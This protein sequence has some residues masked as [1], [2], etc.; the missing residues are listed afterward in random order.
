MREL[1]ASGKLAKSIHAVCFMAMVWQDW[2]ATAISVIRDGV[3]PDL[4]SHLL[5][6]CRF[7]F[8]N[9]LEEFKL[10]LLTGLKTLP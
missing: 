4:G 2:C 9:D 8:G 7:W 6:T 10:M 5:D 1:I 3:L